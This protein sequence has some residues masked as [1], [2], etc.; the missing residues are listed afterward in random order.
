MASK[1]CIML[2]GTCLSTPDVC[3]VPGDAFDIARHAHILHTLYTIHLDTLSSVYTCRR[4]VIDGWKERCR[5]MDYLDI[6]QAALRL[7]KSTK[8]L[9]RYVHHNKMNYHMIGGKYMF[10]VE[11]LDQRRD[12][13][14]APA[15]NSALL[16]RIEMLE[17]RISAISERLEK[18][19][20]HTTYHAPETPP[21]RAARIDRA[22]PGSQSKSA[23]PN[24][25]VGLRQFA[26]LHKIAQS[27]AVKAVNAGRLDVTRGSWP[28]GRAIVTMA[29]TPAQQRQFI[30]LFAGIPSFTKCSD[31]PH[32]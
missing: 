16:E 23:L 15:D 10:S 31:C 8:T 14:V 29:L 19:E 26:D 7:G 27:T 22:K 2:A 18:L 11:D 32:E 1:R 21:A 17:D 20:S 28:A 13:T 5:H 3:L 6:E 9:R 12:K 25:L 24:G 4:R 30:D